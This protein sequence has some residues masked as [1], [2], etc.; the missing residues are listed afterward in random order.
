MN[1]FDIQQYKNVQQ[2]QNK[3]P[4]SGCGINRQP[5]DAETSGSNLQ[6]R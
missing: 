3:N 5:P 2:L 1:L 6:G 4:C